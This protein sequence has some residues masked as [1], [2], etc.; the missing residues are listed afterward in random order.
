M[1]KEAVITQLKVL[2]WNLPGGSEENHVNLRINGVRLRFLLDASRV[3]VRAFTSLIN[4]LGTSF[5]DLV[6]NVVSIHEV[7]CSIYGLC[8][9]SIGI[10]YHALLCGQAFEQEFY[11]YFP[12]PLGAI[13][14]GIFIIIIWKFEGKWKQ[15]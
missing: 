10:N 6:V 15:I 3:Q 4:S 5:S 14:C 1:W 8:R 11:Q 2:F 7:R 13:C 9:A 12:A